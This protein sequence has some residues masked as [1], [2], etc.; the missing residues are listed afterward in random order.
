MPWN[1]YNYR[2]SNATNANI[3]YAFLKMLEEEKANPD[4]M[5]LEKYDGGYE[6]MDDGDN[7]TYKTKDELISAMKDLNCKKIFKAWSR[8]LYKEGKR[9]TVRIED[10][11]LYYSV[12]DIKE[13]DKQY[14]PRTISEALDASNKEAL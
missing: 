7:V 9:T 4:P 11:W 14:E 2:Q 1:E 13:S 12:G 5:E 8:C 10:G 6:P 3:K